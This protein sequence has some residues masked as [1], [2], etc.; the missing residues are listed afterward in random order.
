MNPKAIN[1]VP[2]SDLTRLARDC[3]AS[4][5]RDARASE[6]PVLGGFEDL[7]IWFRVLG[8]HDLK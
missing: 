1:Q 6:F 8:F 2:G 3:L 5:A 4:L 7:K